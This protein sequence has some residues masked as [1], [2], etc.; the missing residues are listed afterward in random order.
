MGRASSPKKKAGR[1]PVEINWGQVDA[2]AAIHCT[3]EEI[4][5]VLMIHKDTLLKRCKA[6]H[7]C[8]MQEYIE[9]RRGAGRA[10]LRRRMWT[11]AGDNGKLMS[12]F[13]KQH[14]GMSEK[15]EPDTPAG[16]HERRLTLR[17]EN[18]DDVQKIADESDKL[19]QKGDRG[20]EKQD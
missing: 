7:K 10:S 15:P 16:G 11:Q 12:V 9:G 6:E 2:M 8:T 14:L 19:Q 1:P 13:A 5:S 18:V 20:Q 4:S 17:I 3:L